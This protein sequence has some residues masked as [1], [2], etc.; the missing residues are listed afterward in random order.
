MEGYDYYQENKENLIKEYQGKWIG[1]KDKKILF[2][3]DQILDLMSILNQNNY[4][5]VYIVQC[6][7]DKKIYEINV[8][9]VEFP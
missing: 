3:S 5:D 7:V 9:R 2:P 1:V 4:E 8:L 6:G